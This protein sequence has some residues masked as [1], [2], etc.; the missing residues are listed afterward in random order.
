[1]LPPLLIQKNT[2]RTVLSSKASD[3]KCQACEDVSQIRLHDA[4]RAAILTCERGDDA[5][6]HPS[7]LK[8]CIPG[9]RKS[10]LFMTPWLWSA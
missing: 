10:Q 1:M 3:A 2:Q 6:G 8:P 4:K 5:H 7:W 9:R